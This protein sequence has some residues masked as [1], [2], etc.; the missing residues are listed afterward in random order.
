M[1]VWLATDTPASDDIISPGPPH[2]NQLF[3]LR[4]VLA[5]YEDLHIDLVPILLCNVSILKSNTRVLIRPHW[6]P[7]DLLGRRGRHGPPGTAQA[8][9]LTLCGRTTATTHR[10]LGHDTGRSIEDV[11]ASPS[12]ILH[13]AR[14]KSDMITHGCIP[15]ISS[16]LVTL[17]S[18]N[19]LAPESNLKRHGLL[20]TAR[21]QSTHTVPSV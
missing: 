1:S 21:L 13:R 5:R 8:R 15:S 17:F 6:F 18:V 12:A 14:V 20:F 3:N 16:H 7:P 9:P 10:L 19:S 11:S 2:H 4:G